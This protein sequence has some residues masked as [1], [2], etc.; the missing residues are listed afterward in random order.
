MWSLLGN[1]LAL[2]FALHRKGEYAKMG[3]L[4][5][6]QRRGFMKHMMT[7]LRVVPMCVMFLMIILYVSPI[8]HV[9]AY[10]QVPVID[11]DGSII[12]L[13]AEDGSSIGAVY[14]EW[15]NEVK[16]YTVRT[17]T[18]DIP[19]G[20]YGFIHEFIALSQPSSQVTFVF[21]EGTTMGIYNLRIFSD[22]HVPDDV[23]IWEPPC[24]RADIL[25]ISSHADDEI[26]FMG[27]IIPTYVPQGAAIQVAY[28][29]EFW[30]TTPIRE[31]E[32]LNGLWR[33]GLR[34]Y[35][36]CGNFKDIYVT[37]I[38]D[39][40]EKYDRSKLVDYDMDLIER[41]R[42]QVVV[43]HDFNGEY[44]HGFHMLTASA[45]AEALEKSDYDVPK[46]YF[47]LYDENAI[48]MD[49]NI[50]I[51]SMGGKTALD[52][53]KE[54]Y[55]KH[56]SQQ[57]CW[58]YVSDTYKYSCAD[59]G[60]YKTTVGADEEPSMLDH[61]VLYS[62]Q[63]RIEKEERERIEKEEQE[64]IQKEEAEKLARFEEELENLRDEAQ[65][66]ADQAVAELEQISTE[67]QNVQRN[68]FIRISICIILMILIL[69]GYF[70][71]RKKMASYYFDEATEG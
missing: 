53:A 50:P 14:I 62:E 44:G 36:V 34:N 15:N 33:E 32:K 38:E 10:E 3:I 6:K 48:H 30:T 40:E 66:K 37:S 19:G 8:M 42:P 55:L 2:A 24:E 13:E 9:R 12:T 22:E 65:N 71:Y 56:E 51:E 1:D 4:K 64:R 67:M 20:T 26:L 28:M 16:P 41:F 70:L 18:G 60:L 59:F 35:P 49:L 46:A 43:T 7:K 47:H 68:T 61:I 69:L 54:A 21:P 52:I 29:T 57:W 17:D 39:A 31:H 23:Q 11:K 25:M 58:Y 63:E 27:G 45:V 5:N